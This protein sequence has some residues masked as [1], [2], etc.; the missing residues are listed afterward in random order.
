MYPHTPPSFAKSSPSMPRPISSSTVKQTRTGPRGIDRSAHQP[1]GSCHDDGD[2]SFVIGPQ[3]RRAVGGDD[4]LADSSFRCG[5][6]LTRITFDGS[7]GSDDVA[8]RDSSRGPPASRWPPE[9]SGEVSTCEFQT[10]IGAACETVAGIVAITMP[11]SSIE[12]SSQPEIAA[13]L[14]QQPA[15]HRVAW[16]WGQ[17]RTGFIRLGVDPT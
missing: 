3:Q 2:A 17:R 14:L 11:C 7:P 10:I 4:R 8:A 9:Y 16:P 5:F 12:T 1:V 13:L 15:E 6:S